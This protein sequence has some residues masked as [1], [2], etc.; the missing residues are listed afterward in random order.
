MALKNGLQL[1]H[2]ACYT[3]KCLEC[4]HKRHSSEDVTVQ[5]G[6]MRA[7]RAPVIAINEPTQIRE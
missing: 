5:R 4:P 3:N 2:G 6:T 7:D 1:G